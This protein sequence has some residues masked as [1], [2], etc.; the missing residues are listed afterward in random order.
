VRSALGIAPV[1]LAATPA[2]AQHGVEMETGSHIPVPQRARIPD[3]SRISDVNRSRI[4]MSEFARCAVDRNRAGVQHALRLPFGDSYDHA[5]SSLATDECLA[6]GMMKFKVTLF[7]GALFTELYR[8]RDYAQKHGQAWNVSFAKISLD[9]DPLAHPSQDAA[10]WRALMS[11]GYCVVGRDEANA[12]AA[13]LL[14]TASAPQ[15]AALRALGPSFNTCL[16]VGTTLTFSK[17][18]IEGVLAEVL[19][20]GAEV[21]ATQT[22]G[23]K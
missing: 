5:V 11:F 17:P 13:I 7:R 3:G 2:L 12:R 16:P 19:Y 15:E 14:P 18:I 4:A 1:L 8:G 10:Q 6:G 23:A 9:Q 22:A 21:P 20:R